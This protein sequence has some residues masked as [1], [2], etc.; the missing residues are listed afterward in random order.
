VFLLAALNVPF[1]YWL[2]HNL[3]ISHCVLILE[4]PFGSLG[5][6]THCNFV[7][8]TDLA[9]S[10]ILP[11][12]VKVSSTILTT[13]SLSEVLIFSP[14]VPEVLLM[15]TFWPRFYKARNLWFLPISIRGIQS[16]FI[17]FAIWEHHTYTVQC[18]QDAKSQTY[19]VTTTNPI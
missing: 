15:S 4:L 1:K 12:M 16:A 10:S 17:N 6:W 14:V 19:P 13:P 5:I 18:V 2:L 3:L 7:C 8:F 9:I 11:A